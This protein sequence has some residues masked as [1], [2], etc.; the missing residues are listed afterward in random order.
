MPSYKATSPY[1]KSIIIEA[2][3]EEEARRLALGHFPN[4]G[5]N[6]MQEESLEIVCL[7]LSQEG[8]R[9]EEGPE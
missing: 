1:G 6:L 9:R 5:A 8:K 7:E 4:L 2:P 3:S